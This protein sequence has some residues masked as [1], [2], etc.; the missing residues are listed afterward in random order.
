MNKE[1]II[2]SMNRFV[3]HTHPW[4]YLTVD[5]FFDAETA[6]KF[7]TKGQ[8]I[9]SN[10]THNEYLAN[11]LCDIIDSTEAREAMRKHSETISDTSSISVIL[12]AHPADT[13]Y[14][15]HADSPTLEMTLI[16]Y[17]G[18]ND[19]SDGTKLHE[20]NGLEYVKTIPFKHNRAFVFF[21]DGK[22]NHRFG[23]FTDVRRNFVIYY[24]RKVGISI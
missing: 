2:A 15:L 9:N 24:R 4:R 22:M 1:H 19:V 11:E 17:I 18:D 10:N 6:D 21:T 5:N 23:S 7:R 20:Y 13:V 12:N 8:E 3:E 14:P 16:V